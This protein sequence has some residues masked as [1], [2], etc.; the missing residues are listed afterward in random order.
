MVLAPRGLSDPRLK[1]TRW[2]QSSEI[3]ILF[4]A[5]NLPVPANNGLASAPKGCCELTTISARSAGPH[6]P[7]CR[8]PSRGSRSDHST[9][10]AAASGVE[11]ARR[12]TVPARSNR[13]TTRSGLQRREP[14]SDICR[15]AARKVCMWSGVNP[16]A[17]VT[18]KRGAS[19]GP[20]PHDF[21][22]F[23]KPHAGHCTVGYAEQSPW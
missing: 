13:R 6:P 21:E 4:V 1:A 10:T 17:S 2:S 20:V 7:V 23:R 5:T 3:K 15:C 9:A 11:P 19:A 16:Q 18:Q 22:S 12:S 8:Y 14:G